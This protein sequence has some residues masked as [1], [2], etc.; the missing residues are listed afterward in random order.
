MSA[1]SS[2]P[3]KTGPVSHAKVMWK[4]DS[5]VG[6]MLPLVPKANTDSLAHEQRLITQ[7]RHFDV[8]SWMDA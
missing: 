2:A 1:L 8:L 7:E 3:K 5:I 4:R 6:G